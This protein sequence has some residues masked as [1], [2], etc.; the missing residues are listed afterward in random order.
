MCHDRE[1]PRPRR[2]SCPPPC[3]YAAAPPWQ[4]QQQQQITR[5]LPLCRG[6]LDTSSPRKRITEPRFLDFFFSWPWPAW[7]QQF[8]MGPLVFVFTFVHKQ[9]GRQSHRG[10]IAFIEKIQSTPRYKYI[11]WVGAIR[12]FNVDKTNRR[13]TAF[14]YPGTRNPR[15]ETAWLHDRV[16]VISALCPR[17]ITTNLRGWSAPSFRVRFLADLLVVRIHTVVFN[18]RKDLL[19]LPP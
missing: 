14:G 2:R 12:L 3:S 6:P 13:L 1:V 15:Q 19:S 17:R 8:E 10:E 7:P 5:R 16:Q 9:M 11:L 18:G 4:G